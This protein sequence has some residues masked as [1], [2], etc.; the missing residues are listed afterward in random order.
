MKEGLDSCYSFFVDIRDLW[1]ECLVFLF[2]KYKR[3][4]G[5]LLL[6]SFED[7]RD[8]WFECLVFLFQKY[9][10]HL[11]SCYSIFVD[12]RY[13]WFECLVFFLLQKYER[14]LGFLLLVF[15]RYKIFVV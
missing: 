7:I 15:C 2:Q 4:L 3:G 5:F 12:I 6:F 8:L 10:E 1:F 14:G 13:L 11:D 9:K